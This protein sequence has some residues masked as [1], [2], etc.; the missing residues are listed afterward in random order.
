M[1]ANL[2][3]FDQAVSPQV[4]HVSPCCFAETGLMHSV[5]VECGRVVDE[6]VVEC[7]MCFEVGCDNDCEGVRE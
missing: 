3:W 4:N 2:K 7:A 5:C 6:P 1:L